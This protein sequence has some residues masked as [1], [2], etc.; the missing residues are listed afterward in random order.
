MKTA[1]LLAAKEPNQEILTFFFDM[2][3]RNIVTK[4]FYNKSMTPAK[5]Y[6]DVEYMSEEGHTTQVDIHCFT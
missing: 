4:R 5:T 1:K 2:T 3:I 6:L